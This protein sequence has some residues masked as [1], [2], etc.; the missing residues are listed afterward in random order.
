MADPPELLAPVSPGARITVDWAIAPVLTNV[1]AEIVSESSKK[2]A[3]FIFKFLNLLAP[4]NTIIYKLF[5]SAIKHLHSGRFFEDVVGDTAGDYCPRAPR[6]EVFWSRIGRFLYAV[7]C[8]EI[9]QKPT[10]FDLE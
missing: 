4:A 8:D 9:K 3:F 1:L 2:C 10:W 5:G 6:V 7:D